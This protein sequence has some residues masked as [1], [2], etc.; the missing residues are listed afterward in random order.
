MTAVLPS[1]FLPTAGEDCIGCELCTERC[2]LGALTMDDETD[3][4]RVEPDKCIGCGVC[5]LTCPQETLQL[6]RHERSI[7]FKTARELVKTIAIENR[8]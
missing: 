5:V 4:P 8:E 6:Y 7:P 2:L 1:N 3:R